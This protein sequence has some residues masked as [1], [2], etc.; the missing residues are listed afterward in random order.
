MLK[1]SA[2]GSTIVLIAAI[3][4]GLV[5]ALIFFFLNYTR[6]M[7]SNAEQKKAIE[8][9]AL[10]A[11]NDMSDIV[12]NTKEFGFVSLSEQAP[13]GKATAAGDLHYLPV[14][15]INTLIGTARLDAVIADN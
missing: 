7:G 4:L 11:A 15:G 5:V 13:I 2:R 9:A 1:R 10:S 6:L 14:H 8:A 3:S 12:I